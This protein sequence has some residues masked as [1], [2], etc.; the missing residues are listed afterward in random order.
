MILFARN[1]RSKEQVAA[2]YGVI[3]SIDQ[4]GGTVA[5]LRE[6]STESPG[7]TTVLVTLAGADGLLRRV[8]DSG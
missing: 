7:E 8:I 2:P 4:E 1:V 5:R 3:I 6:G